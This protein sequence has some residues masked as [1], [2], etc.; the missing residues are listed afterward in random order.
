MLRIQEMMDRYGDVKGGMGTDPRQ[1]ELRLDM[2]RLGPLQEV[3][4]SI[5][6][7][8]FIEYKFDGGDQNQ[9]QKNHY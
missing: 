5:F 4:L 6:L 7:I 2:P 3:D 1:M 9:K 8:S